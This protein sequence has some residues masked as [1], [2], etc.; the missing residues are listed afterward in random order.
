MLGR[1]GHYFV[2]GELTLSRQLRGRILLDNLMHVLLILLGELSE[3]VVNGLSE[4]SR[5]STQL[6]VDLVD[7]QLR[8]IAEGFDA[9]REAGK[10]VLRG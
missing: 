6:T 1:Q 2:G 3:P 9:I 4:M 10:A 8:L 5:E 7:R